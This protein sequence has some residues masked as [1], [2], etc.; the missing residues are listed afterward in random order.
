MNQ[1][2]STF[3]FEMPSQI[4]HMIF[5]EEVLLEALEEE[6][7]AILEQNGNCF[8][9]AC[10]GPD[11]FYHNQRTRPF[12]LKYG[13]AVHREGYGRLV[14]NLVQELLRLRD[15][16]LPSR[17][18]ELLSAYI[19]GFSTHAF[20]DRM[21]HPFI[22]YF[23]G[24]VKVGDPETQ[25]YF[26]CHAYLERI[27]DVLLLKERRNTA[28]G[29]FTLLSLVDC[30]QQ[31]PYLITKT[32]LK[33][34]NIAYPKMRYKSR[35]R[36]R[37]DNAYIDTISFYSFTDPAAT[38]FRQMAFERDRGP[39]GDYRRLAL[40]HP[41]QIPPGCDFLNLEHRSWCHPCRRGLESTASFPD[42]YQEAQDLAVPALRTIRSVLQGNKDPEEVERGLGNGSLN[43]GL[44]ASEACPLECSDPLPLWELIDQLYLEMEATVP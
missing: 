15:R 37:I 21:T 4:S 6:G 42:L 23:A 19:L 36:R 18:D 38:Q 10:Q 8:R 16:G 39:D 30:G 3:S 22:I 28:I 27:I 34:L 29:T 25:K 13:V 41:L 17:D 40:F 1:V 31:L 43:T 11:F 33:S 24:W 9:F 5:G 2:S 26:R 20:L 32:L 14:K 44:E 7:R 12:G 35:D